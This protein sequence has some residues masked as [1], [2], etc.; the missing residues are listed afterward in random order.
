MVTQC[1]RVVSHVLKNTRPEGYNCVPMSQ[2]LDNVP[3]LTWL[4]LCILICAYAATASSTMA[5]V[6][7]AFFIFCGF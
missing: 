4:S 3:I 7:N 5:R 1:Q 2:E 6:I